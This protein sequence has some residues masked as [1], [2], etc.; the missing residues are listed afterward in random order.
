MIDDET[1]LLGDYRVMML[2]GTI[3]N[4]NAAKAELDLA[5]WT[6]NVD[7]VVRAVTA[8]AAGNSISIELVA[9]D[10]AALTEA[11]GVVSITFIPDV[12]T[13]DDVETLIGTS[14]LIEVKTPGTGATPLASGDALLKLLASGS[15]ATAAPGIVPGPGDTITIP[16]PNQTSTKTG[17]I[18]EVT[19]IT[20]ATVTVQVR[21]PAL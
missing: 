18:M 19:A 2:L 7:T 5:D 3:T 12:T 6:D 1:I 10:A 21:G 17:E 13:V 11:L 15:D 4:D 20:Q 8:G 16:P 9:S 14:T